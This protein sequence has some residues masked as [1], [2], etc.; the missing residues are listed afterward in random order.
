M[1]SAQA[2]CAEVW[3]YT[4][5]QVGHCIIAFRPNPIIDPISLGPQISTK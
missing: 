3:K 1:M 2:G 4:D 5:R